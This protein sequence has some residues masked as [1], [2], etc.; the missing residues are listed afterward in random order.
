MSNNITNTVI[1]ALVSLKTRELWSLFST[2]AL[3]TGL[4]SGTQSVFSRTSWPLEVLLFQPDVQ[5]A[6]LGVPH[7]RRTI[8]PRTY[9]NIEVDPEEILL[10][11]IG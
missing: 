3:P 9:R 8:K 1:F 10:S 7:I 11:P 5:S 2:I 4:V 6:S